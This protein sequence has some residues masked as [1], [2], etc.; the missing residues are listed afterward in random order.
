VIRGGRQ[1]A[2]AALKGMEP[3]TL[4][5]VIL[6]GAGSAAGHLLSDSDPAFGAIGAVLGAV[7]GFC[8]FKVRSRLNAV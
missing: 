8:L 7:L 3:S 2:T 5:S 1:F 4:A 6:A